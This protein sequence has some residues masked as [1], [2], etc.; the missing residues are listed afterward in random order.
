[1]PSILIRCSDDDKA[2]DDSAAA[3]A[4]VSLQAFA[5]RAVLDA[6]AVISGESPDLHKMI[7]D[8]HAAICGKSEPTQDRRFP[9]QGD[10]IAALVSMGMNHT[11]AVIKVGLA[12]IST[13]GAPA[14]D[15][16]REALR[17]DAT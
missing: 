14:A 17:K 13:P 7:R 1:M 10:A 9:E 12:G 3:T 16:I 8:I 5:M 4:G 2:T 11:Q 6:A 15:L